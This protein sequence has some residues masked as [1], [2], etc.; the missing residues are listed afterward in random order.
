MPLSFRILGPLEVREDDRELPV[1]TGRQRALLAL[2]LVHANELVSTD[3]LVE[4]LWSG[5]PPPSAQ[6][7]LQ[8]YVSQLRRALDANT[9]LTRSSGYVLVATDTDAGEFER[10]TRLAADQPAKQ[11]VLTLEQALSLWRG[12]AFEEFEYEEW[13]QLEIA[14][15][16]ELRLSAIENRIE[17]ELALGHH[18]R[19]VPELETLVADYPLRERLRGQLMVALYRSGRHADALDVY[20][21]GRRALQDELGLE[22][23]PFLAQLERQILSH[24]PDLAAPARRVETD[25]RGAHGRHRRL[26]VGLVAAAVAG[27]A[28]VAIVVAGSEG[29]APKLL[30][31]SLIRIDPHTLKATQ[32][33]QVGDGPDIVIAS[34]GYLWVM[35]NVLRDSKKSGITNSGDHTLTRVNPAN[36]Q[37]VTVGGALSPC[38]LTSD[39]AGYVWVANCFPRGTGQVSNAVRVNPKTLDFKKRLV[40]PGGV[41][42]FR[43]IAY[44]DGYLWLSDTTRN[45]VI[46]VNPTTGDRRSFRLTRQAD[47]LAWSGG[48]G[49]LWIANN[50]NGSVQQLDPAT[51]TV[52]TIDTF[53]QSPNSILVDGNRVW[54]GDWSQPQV[55]SVSATGAPHSRS[56]DL[57]VQYT[58]RCP[59]YSCVWRV[60]AGAGAIWATTPEDRALWRID[61]N[62]YAVR[63]LR[64]PYPPTGVTAD[65]NNVWV[66]MRGH[67]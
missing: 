37:A 15:L 22:P 42:F 40:V 58:T 56:V 39:P 18:A 33:A 47:S 50:A 21:R 44:G 63:R 35:N 8:G 14:R 52:R 23:S 25:G 1:G 55:V 45:A 24:D 57:P 64:L 43:G 34:G 16:D 61:P 31:D 10:L 46:Q 54:M 49:D 13:P 41:H 27:I 17:A 12:R 32:V 30:P 60:A 20:Q 6:K 65:A 66:T 7:V 29:S 2:L 51:G 36:G 48:N 3:R 9:I 11:A 62:T 26:V 38:G 4:E 28:A 67:Q 19:L 53:A 59:R 5:R